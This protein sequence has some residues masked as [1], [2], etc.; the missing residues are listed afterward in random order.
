MR[1]FNVVSLLQNNCQIFVEIQ[2]KFCRFLC[3]CL[4]HENNTASGGACLGKERKMKKSKLL[5]LLLALAM[6][7]M[8]VLNGC[9]GTPAATTAAPAQTEA[10]TT[11]APTEPET[12]PEPEVVKFAGIPDGRYVYVHTEPAAEAGAEMGEVAFDYWTRTL[13]WAHDGQTGSGVLDGDEL[14]FF[15]GL[16]I[17]DLPVTD[18]FGAA[19]KNT[20]GYAGD[21]AGNF[22]IDFTDGL[23]S[24][25]RVD[26]A[27]TNV[28][29]IVTKDITAET[30]EVSGKTR[31]Q[32]NLL[33]S[34][35]TLDG[36]VNGLHL[37]MQGDVI[38]NHI[39]I[40]SDS[41]GV[42]LYSDKVGGD[43]FIVD[44]VKVDGEVH[45]FNHG[46]VILPLVG[47][48]GILETNGQDIIITGAYVGRVGKDITFSTGEDKEGDIIIVQEPS[49]GVK[50]VD[51]VPTLTGE[52]AKVTISV[53]GK[54]IAGK[55]DV[56]V[57]T[58]D[59]GEVLFDQLGDIIAN[60]VTIAMTTLGEVSPV[61]TKI[62][63]TNLYGTGS[64]GNITITAG[65]VNGTIGDISAPNGNVS[66]HIASA[67]D[68]GE[69]TGKEVDAE[70][71]EA[72][73]A[74][75]VSTSVSTATITID[76][77]EVTMPGYVVEGGYYYR[78]RDLAYALMSS[79]KMFNIRTM[80]AGNLTIYRDEAYTT[81]GGE[82]EGEAL[83][84]QLAVAVIWMNNT[85]NGRASGLEHCYAING[86][87]FFNMDELLN[88][89]RVEHSIDGNNITID[90]VAEYTGPIIE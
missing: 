16:Y 72:S 86:D 41:E 65:I 71:G 51:G 75:K 17:S 61:L 64:N 44:T 59:K 82:C 50:F 48:P 10:A 69:I 63:N 47:R 88:C 55:G 70:I 32:P 2:Y 79:S 40:G 22:H 30:L 87:Y 85:C 12:E 24:R 25:F 15:Q 78:I 45:W 81:V 43:T 66:V 74:N 5:T 27:T 73:D 54:L 90:T 28:T 80:E 84:D 62:G 18:W 36:S 9:S 19:P 1:L 89:I 49:E 11:E 37:T 34:R 53:G 21:V 35:I 52:P 29:A 20:E 13:T 3:L 57:G 6:V 46:A 8:L 83:P 77:K 42:G 4:K 56:I 38:L 58:N 26:A 31:G 68:H 39:E 76:G 33:Q 60:N 14:Q 67:I 7:A 23:L